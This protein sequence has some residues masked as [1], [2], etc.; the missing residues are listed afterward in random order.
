MDRETWWATVHVV[1]KSWTRLSMYSLNSL[2]KLMHHVSLF[3]IWHLPSLPWPFPLICCCSFGPDSESS[4]TRIGVKPCN[5]PFCVR[6]SSRRQWSAQWG[7]KGGGWLWK[8]RHLRLKWDTSRSSSR[9]CKELL[10]EMLHFGLFLFSSLQVRKTL[11]ASKLK[12]HAPIPQEL[13]WVFNS[14]FSV[15]K[16][17]FIFKVCDFPAPN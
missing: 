15:P 9:P 2:R 12:T 4:H 14:L 10:T 11:Y 5:I 13:R 8:M 1:T 3:Q 6:V 16:D 7:L 17:G